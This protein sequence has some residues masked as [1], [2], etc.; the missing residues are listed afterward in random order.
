MGDD[1]S[2]DVGYA[3]PPKGGQFAKGCSGNPKG[4]PKGSKNLASMVLKEARQPV[5]I[6][7]PLG[8]KTVTKAEAGLMQLANKAAQGELRAM[9]QLMSLIQWSEE[10]TAP[11]TEAGRQHETDAQMMQT[12]LQRWA[13]HAASAADQPELTETPDECSSEPK[14]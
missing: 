8:S 5:R 2:Y 12:I 3:K 1:G 4:R 14:A 13:E 6:K 9:H 10:A 7:G 11:K